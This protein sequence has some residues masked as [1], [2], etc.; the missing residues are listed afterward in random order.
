MIRPSLL[1]VDL[2]QFVDKSDKELLLQLKSFRSMGTWD[3]VLLMIEC[4]TRLMQERL[5]EHE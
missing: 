2:K 5:D 3:S 4:V 1:N